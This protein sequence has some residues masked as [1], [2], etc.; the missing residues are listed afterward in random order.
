[1]RSVTRGRQVLVV[2]DNAARYDDIEALMPSRG[3][4]AVLVVSIDELKQLMARHGLHPIR[5]TPLGEDE[6][7]AL[8]GTRIGRERVDAE[9][10]AAT[11]LVHVCERLPLPL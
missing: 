3:E 2:I 6:A 4:S 7:L 1:M 8:L 11:E 10:E 5:L 9:L